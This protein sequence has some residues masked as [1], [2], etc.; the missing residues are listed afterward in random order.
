MEVIVTVSKVLTE[1]RRDSSYS[2]IPAPASLSGACHCGA[3][4]GENRCSKSGRARF[5]YGLGQIMAPFV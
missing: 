3:C 2:D 4:E 1:G 5:R